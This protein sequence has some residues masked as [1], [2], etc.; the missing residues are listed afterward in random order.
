VIEFLIL[1][2]LLM[3]LYVLLFV[4]YT[5]GW[6]MQQQ[7]FTPEL[8]MPST[9]IS[10]VIAV[11]NEATH[12]ALCIESIL[13]NN[14]P[15]HLFEIIVVDDFSNDRT[16]T[17]VASFSNQ[18]VQCLELKHF[19]GK[20]E[21]VYAFKKKAL[22][23]GILHS[24]GKLIIT[25]DG[26][27]IAPKNWLRNFAFEFEIKNPVMIIAPVSYSSSKKVSGIFQTIDFMTM[28]GITIAAHRLGLGSMSNGANLGFSKKAFEEINGYKDINHLASGDDM[29]L[30]A[31]LNKHFPKRIVCLLSSDAVVTT[32]PQ[33]HW[34]SF[35]QQRI[36]WASK[37]GKY[38]D[39]KLTLILCLVYFFNL[40]V[41]L[42]AVFSIYERL[43]L[44]FL[45]L[46]IVVK[47]ITELF[48]LFPIAKFFK[49]K[50]L[51]L[52]F[53][54]LQPIHILYIISAGFFGMIGSYQWKGRRVR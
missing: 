10:V 4:V 49:Q 1:V 31:K 50:K 37:S 30:T 43:C 9:S 54:F 16:R 40:S 25:T 17:I 18:N 21:K 3:L 53:P 12:I 41:L 51:L 13:N 20:E 23:V 52:W 24:T 39:T 26:D 28:Q 29:M 42:L 7:S 8:F 32:V 11:R 2:V 15:K 35:L 48:F 47:I 44:I 33:P 36:R 19:I 45:P 34:K 5:K 14:F 27:C 6:Q 22:E 38:N 46:V